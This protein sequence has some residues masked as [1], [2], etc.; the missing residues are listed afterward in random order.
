MKIENIQCEFFIN[1]IADYLNHKSV[2]LDLISKTPSEQYEEISNTDWTLSKDQKK[3]YLDY[4]YKNILPTPYNKI[5]NYLHSN[6]YR[7]YN[8][9]FQQ[10]E[11]EDTHC[12]HVHDGAN[13][14]NVY[15]IE[16]P[17]SEFK[18][19]LYDSTNKKIL[20]LDIKE[21]DLLT[22]PASVLH[23][24]KPNF[25][26]RK[27]VISFNSDFIFGGTLKFE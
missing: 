25:G 27:T 14:T 16:L 3:E 7:L 24:S 18:T 20:D 13:Y 10:Y 8:G 6:K 26:G 17:D 11:K 21:G 9:W 2:L 19:Q 22:F 15:F 1:S 12:W 4:F 23:R 5:M